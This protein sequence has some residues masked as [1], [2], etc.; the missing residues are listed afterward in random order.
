MLR[1]EDPLRVSSPTNEI[2]ICQ[3]KR[4][5]LCKWMGADRMEKF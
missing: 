5:L 4:P 2:N 3:S 1:P